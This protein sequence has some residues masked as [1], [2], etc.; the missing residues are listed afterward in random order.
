[1]EKSIGARLRQARE[2]RHLS[3][4]QVSETTKIRSQYLQALE[5]DDLSAVPS[6]A[7][8]R[9][10]LRIYA[11][12]LGIGLDELA[13][14]AM[15]AATGPGLPTA[16]ESAV[17]GT[18]KPSTERDAGLLGFFARLWPGRRTNES[19]PAPISP[20]TPAPAGQSAEPT[21]QTASAAADRPT[22]SKAAKKK[23]NS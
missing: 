10:F 21:P 8:A 2:L 4:A 17:P 14:A 9:G 22:E 20:A 18:P 6:T 15:A 13:P 5:S 12:L 1:M 11:E 19:S 7:Q 23:A 16:R 3:L